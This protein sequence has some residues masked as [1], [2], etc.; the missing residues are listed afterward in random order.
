MLC[1]RS[2]NKNHNQIALYHEQHAKR[3]KRRQKRQIEKNDCAV[4]KK[5]LLITQS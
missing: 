4:I 1:R 2:Y 3:R 5:T